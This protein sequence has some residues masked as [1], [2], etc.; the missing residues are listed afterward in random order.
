[1]RTLAT[2]ARNRRR[3]LAAAILASLLIGLAFEV[4]VR[5]I[6]PDSMELIEYSFFDRSSVVYDHVVDN[7][8]AAQRAY[9]AITT[10]LVPISTDRRGCNSTSTLDPVFAHRYVIRFLWHGLPIAVATHDSDYGDAAFFSC[11][12]VGQIDWSV[13]SG[14]VANPRPFLNRDVTGLFPPLYK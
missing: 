5:V 3:A 2:H 9:A 7:A 8:S 11:S 13:S 14:G 4:G 1:M 12:A 6:Q 10:T